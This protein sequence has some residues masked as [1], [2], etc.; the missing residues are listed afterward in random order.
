MQI[1]KNNYSLFVIITS[2]YILIS[3]LGESLLITPELFY[4]QFSDQITFE[5][6]TEL[7]NIG[8]KFSII[9]IFLIPFLYAVKFLL[10]A[11]VIQIGILLCGLKLEFANCF[12]VAMLTEF[13]SIVQ[14]FVKLFWFAYIKTDYTM[15]DLNEFSPLSFYSLFHKMNIQLYWNY[16]LRTLNI[17]ELFYMVLMAVILSQKIEKSFDYSMSFILKYYGTAFLLWILVA[18]FFLVL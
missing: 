5:K 12:R 13:I 15:T 17:F 1:L 10:I 9:G 3:F 18:S 14:S 4:N 16:A 2:I 7:Y 6:A 8:N 11:I